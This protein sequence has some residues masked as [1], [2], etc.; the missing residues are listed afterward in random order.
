MSLGRTIEG[1]EGAAPGQDLEDGEPLEGGDRAPQGGAPQG[2]RAAGEGVQG[3]LPQ[4]RPPP[5][6]APGPVL[7]SGGGESG[8]YRVRMGTQTLADSLGQG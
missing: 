7:A 5:H 3:H 6:R 8:G 1:E 4:H 2:G